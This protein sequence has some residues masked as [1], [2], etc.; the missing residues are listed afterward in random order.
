[1]SIQVPTLAQR[2][3]LR[4]EAKVLAREAGVPLHKALDTIAGRQGFANW[5]LLAKAVNSA[6]PA[7]A[8]P[9]ATPGD[10][11][12]AAH[13]QA[14]TALAASLGLDQTET[15][16]C[17]YMLA[18]AGAELNGEVT[19]SAVFSSVPEVATELADLASRVRTAGPRLHDRREAFANA[20]LQAQS[21]PEGERASIIMR[22]LLV[23]IL[24]VP[25][26]AQVEKMIR[27]GMIAYPLLLSFEVDDRKLRYR[28]SPNIRSDLVLDRDEAGSDAAV[29]ADLFQGS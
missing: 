11:G 25:A 14:F 27:G 24:D 15:A 9:T 13:L 20:R 29:V 19:L 16:L 7:Q 3:R 21:A 26:R 17:R 5:S 22:G 8:G 1:M 18:K 6:G 23:A 2:E 28:F 12:L 4:R 10:A